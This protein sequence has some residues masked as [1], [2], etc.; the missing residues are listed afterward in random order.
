MNKE[1]RK[2]IAET[3]QALEPFLH[4]LENAFEIIEEVR[5]DELTAYENTPETL[6]TSDKRE[7]FQEN[8]SA[9]EGVMDSLTVIQESLGET[10]AMLEDVR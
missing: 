10:F 2:V 4:V 7:L 9:L 5:D 3:L 8:V 6:T 1:R